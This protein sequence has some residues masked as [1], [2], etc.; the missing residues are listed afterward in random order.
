MKHQ[1][2]YVQFIREAFNYEKIK[3]LKDRINNLT[4]RLGIESDNDKKQHLEK[5]IKINKLRLMIAQV[6]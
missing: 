2:T 6:G 1:L 4:K 3:D 5:Q